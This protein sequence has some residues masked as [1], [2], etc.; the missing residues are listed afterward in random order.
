MSLR[1]TRSRKCAPDGRLRESRSCI[2]R[3][4]GLFEAI[5]FTQGSDRRSREISRQYIV[6][7]LYGINGAIRIAPLFQCDLEYAA[8]HAL[9]GLGDVRL[10]AFGLRSQEPRIP[11]CGENSRWAR[12]W[13]RPASWPERRSFP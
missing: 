5:R 4:T 9:E 2:G 10:A 7:D 8:I 6:A 1:A 13:I 3:R 12:T 11:A